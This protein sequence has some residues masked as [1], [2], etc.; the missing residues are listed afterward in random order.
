MLLKQRLAGTQLVRHKIDCLTACSLAVAKL[1]Q[2]APCTAG[3]GHTVQETVECVVAHSLCGQ[4]LSRC[5]G[6]AA[7]IDNDVACRRR[8]LVAL[9]DVLFLL[10]AAPLIQVATLPLL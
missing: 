6:Q 9:S 7:V 4:F 2:L 1:A 5:F 10:V 3:G 8:S